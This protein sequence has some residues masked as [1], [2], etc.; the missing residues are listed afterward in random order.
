ME[1]LFLDTSFWLKCWKLSCRDFLAWSPK[2]TCYAHGTLCKTSKCS[3]WR[4][5]LEG[6]TSERLTGLPV[7]NSDKRLYLCRLLKDDSFYCTGYRLQRVPGY[8]EHIIYCQASSL[9]FESSVTLHPVTTSTFLCKKLLVVT[10]IH[11]TSF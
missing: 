11:C 7:T 5:Y 3:A 8:C 4:F 2:Q 1:V 10:G 6:L 9:S